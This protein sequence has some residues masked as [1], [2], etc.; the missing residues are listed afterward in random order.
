[1]KQFQKWDHKAF[2][3]KDEMAAHWCAAC[4]CPIVSNVPVD[5]R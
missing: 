5:V 1:M 3:V 4:F 2:E